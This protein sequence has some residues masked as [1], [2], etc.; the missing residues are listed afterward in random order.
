MHSI[1][2]LCTPR[3]EV[4][5]GELREDIFAARLKDV[6]D[7]S[8]DPVYG[9]AATFFDNTYPTEGLRTLLNDAL[10]RLVGDATGKNAIIRLET[11]FGGGKTHNLIA[12]YHVAKG[13]V[14]PE[15]ISKFTGQPLRSPIP[16][17]I[18]IAG[19]VGSDLDPTIGISHPEL[20]VTTLT[21]WGELAYQLGA[22]AGY[23]LV[24]ESDLKKIAPGTGLFE[25]LVGDQPAL[26][27]IDEIARHLRAAVAMPTA[28]GQSTLADQTVAFLMSLLEFAASQ[29][30]CL[31]VLTLASESDAFA[32]ETEILR[33]K[34]AETL[35]ISARQERVLTPTAEGEIY[36][37]VAHRLFKS[38]KHTAVEDVLAAYAAYYQS[39]VEKNAD[40]PQ[41]C[42]RVEY[43]D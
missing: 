11:A 10:G 26:I 27:L 5:K 36:A 35:Q 30:R 12:L 21:L 28:T 14:D 33:R 3:D 34:L 1:F 19:V 13:D 37:I 23:E 17:E 32:E 9:D 41:R 40:L 29:E 2:D 39:M 8:A 31:V 15:T 24:K 16:G 43:N 6:M 18:K 20:G 22:K 7:S 4:L 38:I 42:L 25:R